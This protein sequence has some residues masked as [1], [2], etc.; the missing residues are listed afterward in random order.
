MD[1]FNTREF[2]DSI[3]VLENKNLY[4]SGSEYSWA[5]D[6]ELDNTYG[7][8]VCSYD[9]FVDAVNEYVTGDN[10][11]LCKLVKLEGADSETINKMVSNE[12]IKVELIDLKDVFEDLKHNDLLDIFADPESIENALQYILDEAELAGDEILIDRETSRAQT[13]IDWAVELLSENKTE[14]DCVDAIN[15]LDEITSKVKS[16]EISINEQG[17]AEE[18][19]SVSMSM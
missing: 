19:L 16:G 8:F 15:Q 14:K 3:K 11:A 4:F 17:V 13:T 9:E 1:T 2:L 18:S 5:S 10:S 7:D 12:C 6:E